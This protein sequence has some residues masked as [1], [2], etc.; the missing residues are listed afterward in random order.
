M[1]RTSFLIIGALPALV[2]SAYD[3]KINGISYNFTGNEAE[4]TYSNNNN[5]TDYSG[6]VVIPDSVVYKGKIYS[7]TSIGHNAFGNCSD[8]TSVSIPESVTN[9]GYWA[10]QGCRG[11]TSIIIPKGVKEINQGVFMNC[12]GLTSVTIPECVTSIGIV[13]FSNCTSLVS[14]TIPHGVTSIGNAA[15]GHCHSLT[16]ITIPEGIT[17]IGFGTFSNCSGLTSITIPG[18]VTNIESEAFSDCGSLTSVIISEGVNNI[19]DGAFYGCR[20]LRDVYCH[21]AEP[22]SVSTTDFEGSWDGYPFEQSYIEEHTTLHVPASSLEKYKTALR[23][24]DFCNIVP[25]TGTSVKDIPFSGKSNYFDLQGRRLPQKPTQG[26]YIE[27]RK[28]ML[29]K[30]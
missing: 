30:P 3:A 29:V 2:A 17:C 20:S 1:K 5:T 23:W 13:A 8:L 27:N 28:K 22:P 14:V 15:F 7:V 26:I 6:S 19:E 25:I 21:A 9:I 11:L 12:T 4:V 18:S 24:S 16:S 10:F